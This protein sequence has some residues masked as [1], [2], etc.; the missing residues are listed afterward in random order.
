[1]NCVSYIDNYTYYPNLGNN[2]PEYLY[3]PINSLKKARL[4]T[5]LY[6]KF[7]INYFYLSSIF[8]EVDQIGACL[9]FQAISETSKKL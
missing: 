1:M 3:I 4:F 8:L 9:K 5:I 2:L 6:Y 7:C